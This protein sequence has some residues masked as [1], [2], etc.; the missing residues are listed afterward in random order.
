MMRY[1]GD[2]RP[3]QEHDI[4]S[5]QSVCQIL[6]QPISCYGSM[7]PNSDEQNLPSIPVEIVWYTREQ[8]V[9]AA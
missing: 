3:E 6:C 7:A 5:E 1:G 8:H 4:F 2:V 9:T